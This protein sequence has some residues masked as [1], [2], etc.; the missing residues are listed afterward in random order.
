MVLDDD[1]SVKLSKL[2]E[3]WQQGDIVQIAG[4]PFIYLADLRN[5]ITEKSR[6]FA[7]SDPQSIQ[8][9]PFAAIADTASDFVIVSQSCDIIKDHL[10]FPTIQIAPLKVVDPNTLGNAKRGSSASFLF[11]PAFEAESIAANLDHIMT[12]EKSVLLH[13]SKGPKKRAVRSDHEIKA[14]GVAIARKFNRFAFPDDFNSALSRF[15][16]RV[17]EKG[18]KNSPEGLVYQ[19]VAEIRIVPANAW[20][21]IQ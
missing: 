5:P 13:A 19:S 6:E 4:L 21:S 1:Q 8:E 10:K 2:L 9:N 14:L 12:M 20:E 11:L 3:E 18:R 16:G 15:Q 7:E 17:V